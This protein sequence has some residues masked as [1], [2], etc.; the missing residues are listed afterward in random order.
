[1]ML[2]RFNPHVN[3]GNTLMS[4]TMYVYTLV[5]NTKEARLS[6]AV[7]L[8]HFQFYNEVEVGSEYMLL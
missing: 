1:M 6:T 5:V 3:P 4:K 2:L 7:S 8:L